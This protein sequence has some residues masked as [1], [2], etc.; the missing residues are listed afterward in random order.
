[1]LE[2]RTTEIYSSAKRRY[3]I[4]LE[5]EYSQEMLATVN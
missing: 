4:K 2:R 5:A 1:V 3:L